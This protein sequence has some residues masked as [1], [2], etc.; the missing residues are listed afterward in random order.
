M[1]ATET[2][3]YE[4]VLIA[5]VVIGIILLYFIVLF[6]RQQHINRGL[7]KKNMLNEIAV[8]EKDRA[9]IAAD[10]HDELGPM[11]S[12]VKMCISSFDLP[13]EYDREQRQNAKE[14][15]D[16]V[17]GKIREISYDLMPDTVIKN[18]LIRAL[19]EYI[20]FLNHVNDIRFTFDAPDHMEIPE[21]KSVNIYRIIQELLYNAIKHANASEIEIE[22]I[23]KRSMLMLKVADN[24]T[25]FDYKQKLAERKGIGLGSL[26]NR[27]RL[28]EGKM[29]VDS[30]PAIGSIFMF[31]IPF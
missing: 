1:D 25:G 26:A 11:L 21:D 17:I 13:D 18:G 20:S 29:F 7:R 19:R 12:F 5:S 24:G 28:A 16:N 8:L 3:I 10:L 14:Q 4:G 9:R 30:G 23:K 31:E 27:T 2:K 6:I 15:I 22:I